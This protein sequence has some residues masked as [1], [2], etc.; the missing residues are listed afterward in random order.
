MMWA[1]MVLLLILGTALETSIASTWVGHYL[2]I[3]AV[4]PMVVYAALVAGPR[5]GAVTG[6]A[7]GFFGDLVEPHSLGRGALTLT[8][9]GYAAGL[10]GLKTVRSNVATQIA[11][12]AAVVFVRKAAEAF[13]GG[14]AIATGLPRLLL[15]GLPATLASALLA[16][17]VFRGVSRA[18]GV[19]IR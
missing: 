5:R 3:D 4:S 8:L 9:L 17:W 7:A 2:P 15:L 19:R 12:V 16:A 6:F 18:T 1:V 13:A 10:A 11:I 14:A